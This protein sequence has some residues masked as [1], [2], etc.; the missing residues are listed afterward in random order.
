[1]RSSKTSIRVI[2]SGVGLG[3]VIVQAALAGETQPTRFNASDQATAKAMTL[4]A[5]DLGPGWKGGATRPDLTV[6]NRCGMKRSDLVLTGAASSKFTTP[7]ALVSSESNVLQS[8][9]MVTSEWRR[10]FGNVGFMACAGR[11]VTESA[12]MKIVSFK[13]RAF[14]KLATYAVRYRMLA[15]YGAAGSSTRIL[16]DVIYLGKGRSE[17]ALSVTTAY[18]QRVQTD[19]AERRLAQLLVRRM[20]A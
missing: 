13:K 18:A 3:L 2:V 6:D 14:P 16:V 12:Q 9:G 17:V 19:A 7:G 11:L 10:S 8:P 5:T 15:D 1:M 20:N 4:K